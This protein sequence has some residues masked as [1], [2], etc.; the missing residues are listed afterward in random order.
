MVKM[1]VFRKRKRKGG[2]NETMRGEGFVLC[3]IARHGGEVLPGEI[4]TEMDVS[5]AR[6][7][8]ALNSLE[9][10]GFITRKIDK[11]DRRKILVEITPSGAELSEKLYSDMLERFAEMLAFLGDH[12]A[13]EYVR[14]TGRLADFNFCGGNAPR[15]QQIPPENLSR[16]DPV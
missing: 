2:F 1:D 9:N 15:K 4:S 16:P 7:A 12:D 3:Y 8:S 10:K 13:L 14:I 6:V 11:S 5:S